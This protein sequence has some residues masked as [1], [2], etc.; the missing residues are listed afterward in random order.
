MITAMCGAGDNAIYS[1][2][3]SASALILI[4]NS[5]LT[6][7]MTPWAYE[8]MKEGK[9]KEIPGSI[10]LL[11]VLLAGIVCGFVLLAPEAI[12]ILAGDKYEQSIYLI[13]SLATTMY[14]IFLYNCLL[15]T[16]PS[17]RD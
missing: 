9:D 11:Y 2:A 5:S 13:P 10:S 15:Y 4:F 7:A 16:S 6:Q 17:P 14:F 1:V 12:W 3:Y 8:K